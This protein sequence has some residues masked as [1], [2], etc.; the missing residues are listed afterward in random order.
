[1]VAMVASMVS[2]A[3]LGKLDQ[4]YLSVWKPT[5]SG[6]PPKPAPL[7][8]DSSREIDFLFNPKDFTFSKNAHIQRGA[9]TGASGT[10]PPHYNGPGPRSFTVEIFLD[11][12][13]DPTIDIVKTVE[14]MFDLCEPDPSTRNKTDIPM[15]QPFVKFVWGSFQ[16]KPSHVKQVSAK[17]SMFLPTGIPLRA[18]CT[19]Q[20]EE[21]NDDD[22]PQ[23]P[24][25]GSKDARASH[26]VLAGETL[27]S[28]AYQEFHKASLWRAIASTNGID[29]PARVA[30][31]TVL[32]LP[33]AAE[34]AA[35]A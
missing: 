4:A 24:T 5:M 17:F 35:L 32:L 25:S 30:P 14:K 12:L 33:T 13:Q 7:S 2:S 9:N 1:M 20:L 18:T 27:A 26:T 15:L 10:P 3:I 6:D 19:I 8:E 31:G 29:D 11:R 16:S 22:G 23:N 34:A 21:A 28:I